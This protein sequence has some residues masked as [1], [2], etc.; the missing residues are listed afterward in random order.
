[1]AVGAP[2]PV[3][4]FI[5]I[6]HPSSAIVGGCYS[7]RSDARPAMIAGAIAQNQQLPA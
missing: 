7:A 3:A 1:M 2:P 4:P 6:T 5:P